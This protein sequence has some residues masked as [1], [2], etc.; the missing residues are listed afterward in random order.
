MIMKQLFNLKIFY[1]KD[2]TNWKQKNSS[3]KPI[4]LEMDVVHHEQPN[5]AQ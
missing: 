2:G 1:L 3:E 5:I 4:V